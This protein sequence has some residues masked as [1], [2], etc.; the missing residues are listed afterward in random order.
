VGSVIQNSIIERGSQVEDV[1]LDGS[2]IGQ[3]TIVKGG[4]TSIN[5]GDNTDIE[6]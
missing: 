3:N 5:V 4:S 6:I 2:L 1:L